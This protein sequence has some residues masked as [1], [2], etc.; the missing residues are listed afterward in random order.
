MLNVTFCFIET[1]SSF[2]RKIRVTR[3]PAVVKPSAGRPAILAEQLL[4]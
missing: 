4:W 2:T 1:P 3:T